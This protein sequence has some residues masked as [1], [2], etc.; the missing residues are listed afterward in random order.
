MYMDTIFFLLESPLNSFLA[1]FNL[2][3][4]LFSFIYSIIFLVCRKCIYTAIYPIPYVPKTPV[5]GQ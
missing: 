1:P 4:G 5:K 2:L 3:K